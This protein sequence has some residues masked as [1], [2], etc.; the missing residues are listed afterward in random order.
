MNVVTAMIAVILVVAVVTMG[1]GCWIL[2]ELATMQRKE[3]DASGKAHEKS[4]GPAQTGSPVAARPGFNGGAGSVAW[5]S[6]PRGLRR[7]QKDGAQKGN[8]QALAR[9]RRRG[10][11]FWI[12]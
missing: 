6:H 8:A 10:P 2:L 5:S 7:R 9:R 12:S 3:H 11:F 4:E 1:L